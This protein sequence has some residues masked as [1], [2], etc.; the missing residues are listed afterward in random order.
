[1]FYFVPQGVL[2]EEWN[3][4]YKVISRCFVYPL[5]GDGSSHFKQTK[6]MPFIPSS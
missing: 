2:T 6:F 1:M 3:H 5:P 4:L